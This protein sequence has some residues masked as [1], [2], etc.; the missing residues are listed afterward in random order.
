MHSLK[1]IEEQLRGMFSVWSVPRCYKQDNSGVWLVAR[2]SPASKDMNMEDE[3][4][5]TLEAVTRRQPIKIRKT[6]K[7]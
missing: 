2:Q 7:T 1:I 3:E 6:K 4:S 5:T